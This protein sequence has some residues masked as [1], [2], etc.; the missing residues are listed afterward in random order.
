MKK[1]SKDSID[2]DN[3]K[4]LLELQ[5]NSNNSIST[6]AKN[7]DFS[8]QKVWRA[9]HELEKNRVIWGY[10]AITD[11]RKQDLEKF[12]LLLK[13]SA[14]VLDKKTADE[15]AISRLE[16]DYIN[17]G[18]NIESSYYIHGEYDWVLIF[19]ARDLKQAKKFSNLLIENYPGIVAKI[20]LM[21]IL[22]TQR[23][24][25]ILNPNATELREFL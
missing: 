8:K 24:N 16:K 22:F 15:I 9:I 13:R 20:N 12:I 10:S 5:K 23:M 3:K 18:I 11:E 19:T 6:I 2:K 7:C 4:I 1:I 25:N 14:Q 21:Q 17:M